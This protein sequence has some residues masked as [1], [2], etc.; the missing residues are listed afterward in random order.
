MIRSSLNRSSQGG[1]SLIEVL[2]ALVVLAFGLL[3]LALLQTVNLKYTQSANQRTQAVNLAGQILDMMRSNRSQIPAY[4]FEGSVAG[5]A[6]NCISTP[7]AL[8][9]SDN[10]AAWRCRVKKTLG[11]DAAVR[12][13][14]NPTDPARTDVQV[15]WTENNASVIAGEGMIELSTQI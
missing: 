3:G 11:A 7:A 10:L 8:G 9:A 4:Y 14:P 12:I 15:T 2:I 13:R 1:F 5:V 6:N